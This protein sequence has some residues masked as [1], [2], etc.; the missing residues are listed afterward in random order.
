MDIAFMVM[1]SLP[2]PPTWWNTF[3]LEHV[4]AKHIPGQYVGPPEW[5]REAR[6]LL[7]C[8]SLESLTD[9]FSSAID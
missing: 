4:L 5:G 7:E 3:G 1:A 2:P 6:S 8:Q 9:S